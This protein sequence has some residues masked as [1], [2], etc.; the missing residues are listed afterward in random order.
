MKINFKKFT[1]LTLAS[2]VITSCSTAQMDRLEW[3]GKEPP[4]APVEPKTQNE[5]I[6]WPIVAAKEGYMTRSNNSLWSKNSKDFFK[7]GRATR[8]GDILTVKIRINDRAELDNKTERK[9]TET[10]TTGVPSFFG[11]QNKLLNPLPGDANPSSLI[12]TSAQLDNSGEGIIER[13][14]IIETVVAAVVTDVLPN[15][16]MLIYGSQEVRVNFEVRQLTIQGVIRPADIDPQNEIQYS[17]IA[18]ARISY[19]GKGVITDIQQ[20]RL[21]NQLADILSPW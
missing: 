17:Q 3:L 13:E 11:L 21:G 20:P 18:E 2:L 16:N 14:E 7:D 4:M 1:S 9:R 19:G 5:P 6:K 12:S 8:V 15:G 10:D